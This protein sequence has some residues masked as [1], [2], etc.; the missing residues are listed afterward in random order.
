M[1]AGEGDWERKMRKEER[2]RERDT[3]TKLDGLH[4]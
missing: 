4:L 1:Q 2:E 3:Y